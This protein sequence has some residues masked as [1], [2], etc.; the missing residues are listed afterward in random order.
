[1]PKLTKGILRQFIDNLELARPNTFRI[2]QMR[3]N[4]GPEIFPFSSEQAAWRETAFNPYCDHDSLEKSS[5]RWTNV[6]NTNAVQPWGIAPS[7]FG[8]YLDIRSGSLLVV[9]PTSDT[10]TGDASRDFF[11]RWDRYLVD[12][13]KLDVDCFADND[14]EAVRLEAGNR[15]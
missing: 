8:S 9:V 1:V 14:F 4:S 2:I 3:S 5:I 6:F 12:W 13:D 15:L 11:T 10:S 7:G